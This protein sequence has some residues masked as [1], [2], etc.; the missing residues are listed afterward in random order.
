MLVEMQHGAIMNDA[1]ALVLILLAFV[2][3]YHCGNNKYDKCAIEVSKDQ[4]TTVTI[5]HY[6]E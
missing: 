2:I 3:G 4:I 6:D 5:G 1:T